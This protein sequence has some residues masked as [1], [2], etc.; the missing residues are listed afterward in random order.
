MWT[1]TGT[2]FFSDEVCYV[3]VNRVGAEAGQSDCLKSGDSYAVPKR[4]RNGI[5]KAP[6]DSPLGSA[7]FS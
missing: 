4:T 2:E 6:L 3:V 5:V 1:F 7:Y